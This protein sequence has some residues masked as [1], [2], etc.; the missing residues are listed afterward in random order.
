MSVPS[1]SNN[2]QPLFAARPERELLLCAARTHVSDEVA[3]RIRELL[4]ENLNWEYLYQQ[5]KRH[6]V[7]QLIYWQLNATAPGGT[8][9]VP[10]KKLKDNYRDNA[11]RNLFL[12]GELVRIIRSF[13]ENGVQAIP[14]KGPALALTAYGNLA[15]RRFVDLDIMVRKQDVTRAIELLEAHGYQSQLQLNAAQRSML[16][17]AQHNFPFTRDEGRL[18]VELHWEV[19]ARRFASSLSA[20][21]M[22]GRLRMMTI[23]HVEMRTLSTEDLLLSLC[24]HGAKH[25]WERLAWICD[26]A[27]LINSHPDLDWPWIFQRAEQSGHKRMLL[28]GLRLSNELLGAALPEEVREKA[29][30]G[31]E[32]AALSRQVVERMFEGSEYSPAG[33]FQAMRFNVS[34]R[35][36]WGDKFR[37]LHFIMTPTDGDLAFAALPARLSFVYYLLR[38]LRLM[39]KGHGEH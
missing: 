12:A 18:I 9:S 20:E 11:A 21:A 34:A 38:P 25:L 33:L 5:A 35:K 28:L 13:E 30:A 31:K 17:A 10:L 3:R 26:V 24:V 22:W 6:S 7:L 32:V 29:F 23:N 4:G 1:N 27:E 15:L 36:R 37:Y 16:L 39:L 19:A 14:Y 2:L 8:P